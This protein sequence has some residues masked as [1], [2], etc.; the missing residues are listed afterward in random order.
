MTIA[1]PARAF[2]R[3]SFLLIAT[4]LAN[5]Q[6]WLPASPFPDWGATRPAVT[7]ALPYDGSASP[8]TN[9]A[10]LAAAVAAL[11]P[12]QGLAL[13]AGTWS[14]AS[15]L[16]LH[17]IGTANAPFR[18]FAADPAHRPVITRPDANQNV[19]NVGSNAPARYWVLQDLELRGG[20]DLL[21]LYDCA[22]IWVDRCWLHDG[23]GVG[24]AANTLNTAFLWLTRNEIARPGP[25]TTGEGMYLGANFGAVTTSWSVVAC[26]HVHDTRGA[27]AGQG[28]GIEL[29]QGSHHV[30]I[31]G[32]VVHDTKNPCILVYGTGG[33]GENVVEANLVFDSDD[34]SLQ[35]QGEAIVRNNAAFNLGTGFQSHDHQGST[36]DL[37]FVHNT[38]V[39]QGTAAALQ[40]WG[41]RPGMTFAN[42][43]AY[44]LGGESLH[45]GNGAAAVRMAGNVV[46]G[47]VTGANDGFVA[48]HGLAD[49]VDASLVPLR[50]NVTPVAG[51]AIDNRGAPGFA[52]PRDA[53]GALRR[54]PVDP[55]AVTNRTTLVAD[56]AELPLAAGGTQQLAFAAPLLAN[57]SYH[58]LGSLAGTLPGLPFQDF[59]LPLDDDWWLGF[60]LRHGNSG[61]LRNTVGTID[62]AGHAVAQLTLPPL[63]PQLRGLVLQH[64]VIALRGAAVAF[65]SNPVAL[66]LR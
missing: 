38:I 34:G 28:D 1:A 53:L 47:A 19:I 46:L 8:A 22:Y 66:T 35:V 3:P 29:K 41:G 11:Q 4:N 48:G 36:R 63:P 18:L 16:D 10:R 31:V 39:A 56:V 14:V 13:G 37:A 17:G 49:F 45:F 21:R 64:A 58:V 44:S 24:I 61:P 62:A 12:G 60:T 27:V 55:G 43:V 30:W 57:A 5:A 2:L 52:L 33:N 32:N 51:G 59:T 54:L 15:R 40:D 9:G 42:N 65:V 20:S 50:M 26:N 7:I 23:G 6:S 25:G